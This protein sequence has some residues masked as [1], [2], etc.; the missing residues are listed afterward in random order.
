[1]IRWAPVLSLILLAQANGQE[2]SKNEN[3]T[4]RPDCEVW[5]HHSPRSPQVMH[6]IYSFL[7]RINCVVQSCVY[8]C[9]DKRRRNRQRGEGPP[10]VDDVPMKPLNPIREQPEEEIHELE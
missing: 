8:L 2:E 3:T 7:E 1:M 4:L 10:M 6:G 5:Q 9:V